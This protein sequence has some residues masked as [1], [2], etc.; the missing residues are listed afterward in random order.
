MAWAS[1][2]DFG[3]QC[4]GRRRH[5][6]ERIKRLR[7]ICPFLADH[8]DCDW[9]AVVWCDH[10]LLRLAVGQFFALVER[11]DHENATSTN[12]L[13]REPLLCCQNNMTRAI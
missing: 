3:N 5:L 11:V 12:R 8:G 4:I 1:I 6:N 2:R 13:A 9:V 10:R 7:T